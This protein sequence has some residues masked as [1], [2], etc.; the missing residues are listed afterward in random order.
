MTYFDLCGAY[1]TF[2]LISYYN[3]NNGQED[4]SHPLLFSLNVLKLT[5]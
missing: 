1:F 2:Y 4:W 3:F 5:I